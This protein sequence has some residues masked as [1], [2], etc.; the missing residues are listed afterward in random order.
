MAI[1]GALQVLAALVLLAFGW[2]F[3]ASYWA[4]LPAPA[5]PPLAAELA[6]AL[7]RIAALMT[8]WRALATATQGWLQ[9][10]A[11]QLVSPGMPLLQPSVVGLGLI[12]TGLV[13][14]VGNAILLSGRLGPNARR[15]S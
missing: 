6:S 10:T 15:N 1:F 7:Q 13:W 4:T 3:V 2:P 12:A 14:L 9:T 11:G 8:D 5:L